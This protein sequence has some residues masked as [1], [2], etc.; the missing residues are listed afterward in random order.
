MRGKTVEEIVR[1]ALAGGGFELDAAQFNIEEI[2]RIALA[3]GGNNQARIS[4]ANWAHFD[5]EELVRISLAGKGSVFF[6]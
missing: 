4:V 5:T 1:I 2:V 3:A 6:N